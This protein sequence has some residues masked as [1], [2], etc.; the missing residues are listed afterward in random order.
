V[1]KKLIL[2]VDHDICRG[3][4]RCVKVCP[5]KALT[6]KEGKAVVDLAECDLDGTCIP[7]CPASAISLKEVEE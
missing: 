3:H 5:R 2:Y 1:A 6:M 7:A 4:A